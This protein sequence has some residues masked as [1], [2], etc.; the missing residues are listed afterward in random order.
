MCFC[1]KEEENKRRTKS[2]DVLS[3]FRTRD[4]SHSNHGSRRCKQHTL[5]DRNAAFPCP[6]KGLYCYISLSCL[7]SL[8]QVLIQVQ[9]LIVGGIRVNMRKNMGI[10]LWLKTHN[11]KLFTSINMVPLNS[12]N[13]GRKQLDFFFKRKA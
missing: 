5:G 12:L 3:P 11:K 4:P 1:G 10:L 9:F 6:Y 7:C 13:R 8:V 2:H